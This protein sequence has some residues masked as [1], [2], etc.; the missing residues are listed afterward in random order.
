MPPAAVCPA[1]ASLQALLQGQAPEADAARLEQHLAVCPACLSRLTALAGEKEPAP[2]APGQV[3][4]ARHPVLARL[5]AKMGR[6]AP[7][8]LP[9]DLLN[10]VP[11]PRHAVPNALQNTGPVSMTYSEPSLESGDE[12][13]HFLAPPQGPGEMG[14]LGGY[15]VLRLLGVGGMGAVYQA[16]DVALRRHVALK[17]M[18]PSAASQP[19]IRD[20]FLREA[21]AAAALSHDHIVPIFQVGEDR[22]VPFLAMPLLH[23]E[24]LEDRL[25]RVGRLPVADALR[26]AREAAEGLAVA[27]DHGIIHRD[28]KPANIWL[29]TPNDRVKIVDF[30]LASGQ[31]GDV[32]LTT[33]GAIMGTPAY[34]APEQAGGQ[35]DHRADLFSL[36]CVLYRMLTGRPAFAGSSAMEILRN[37]AVQQPRSPRE[38]NPEVPAALDGFLLRLLAKEREQRPVSAAVTAK[39]LRTLEGQLAGT[40]LLPP[41]RPPLAA[42]VAAGARPP[43]AQL[44][45]KGPNASPARHEVQNVP[46][47][48]LASPQIQKAP[49][50]VANGFG[51]ALALKAAAVRSWALA[52]S[53]RQKLMAAVFGAAAVLAVVL[54][55]LIVALMGRGGSRSPVG[56]QPVVKDGPT[57]KDVGQVVVRDPVKVIPSPGLIPPPPIAPGEP[58]NPNSIVTRPAVIEGLRGWDIISDHISVLN[59]PITLTFTHDGTLD[60]ASAGP[61]TIWDFEKGSLI[62]APF[63]GVYAAI[64]PDRATAAR[65]LAQSVQLFNKDKETELARSLLTDGVYAVAW[66][67]GGDYVATF[68]AEGLVIWDPNLGRRVKASGEVV[69]NPA[70]AGNIVWAPDDASI[71][72]WQPVGGTDVYQIEVATGKLLTKTSVQGGTRIVW[73]RPTGDEIAV[74]CYADAKM[75]VYDLKSSKLLFTF[76]DAT[77]A[78]AAW[79]PDARLLAL[80][81]GRTVQ[82]WNCESWKEPKLTYTLDHPMQESHGL[83]FAPHGDTLFSYDADGKLRLWEVA[84]GKHRGTIVLFG[85]GG[86]LA[87]TAEGDFRA[88]ENAAESGMFRFQAVENKVAAEPSAKLFLAKYGRVNNPEKPLKQ[89]R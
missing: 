28:I 70:T 76:P 34:M 11:Q 79:S 50:P 46:P 18:K 48:A 35:V 31:D 37:I 65:T 26:I 16:E 5:L 60:M 89:L 33:P 68:G 73:L 85:N 42:P 63:G 4:A 62:P 59:A 83:A 41:T 86:W 75:R 15:R 55:F 84:T 23:G 27:H 49:A 24:M 78:A 7:T 64:S 9:A 77:G 56:N 43:V 47:A 81:V 61:H 3:A 82:V 10:T 20:R 25:K 21:R 44:I 2:P 80:E 45:Q 74:W 12:V 39:V 6:P 87:A 67:H 57:P 72:A 54:L 58:L 22:G 14:R 29:E 51:N 13:S 71:I 69:A 66:S 53:P 52:L 36:G 19:G 1:P 17:T 38:L 30:G 8:A 32:Q 88:S 40:V